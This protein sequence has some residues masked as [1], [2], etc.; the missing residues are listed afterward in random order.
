MNNNAVEINFYF[1]SNLI[2]LNFTLASF[3]FL[4]VEFS[5]F[6]PIFRAFLKKLFEASWRNIEFYF[7]VV[8]RVIFMNCVK[9]CFLFSNYLF[10]SFCLNCFN[11]VTGSWISSS[12]SS[13]TLGRVPISNARLNLLELNKNEDKMKSN[14][15]RDFER[16][17]T[18]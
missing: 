12:I 5:P 10:Q 9:S 17:R 8:V 11:F 16:A 4:W 13:N 1:F 2:A 15:L 14:R 7:I 6:Q 18:V 3:S